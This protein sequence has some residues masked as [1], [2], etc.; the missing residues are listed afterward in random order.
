[1]NGKRDYYEVLGV[2]R[3]ASQQ[4]IKR[5]YRRLARQHHPDVNPG[6][7]QAE[8]RFKEVAE[9]Y[10]TLSDPRRRHDYDHFGAARGGLHDFGFGDLGDIFESFFGGFEGRPRGRTQTVDLRGSDLRVDL[11]IT[12]EEAAAGTEKACLLYTSPSPRD[13][14]RSRMP[15]SA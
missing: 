4:D 12:L 5:A 6:D 10:E 7:P 15:S 2:E 8:A 11:E 3:G 14:T 13:R 9:A 1:M